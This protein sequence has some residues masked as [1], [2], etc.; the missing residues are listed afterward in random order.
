MKPIGN[1]LKELQSKDLP[2]PEILKTLYLETYPI[3]EITRA[4]RINSSKLHGL[5]E[6]LNLF[7]MRC[8]S[9]HRFFA[10]PALHAENAHYCPECRRWFDEAMLRDEID[11]EIRRLKEKERQTI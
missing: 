5:S 11:L 6:R 3:F 2:K 7:H 8:P 10:E 1:R 9:G 4:L